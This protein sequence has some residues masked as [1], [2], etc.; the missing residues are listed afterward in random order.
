MRVG[1]DDLGGPPLILSLWQAFLCFRLSLRGNAFGDI[2][3]LC[4]KSM[5]KRTRGTCDISGNPASLTGETPD[6][7]SSHFPLDPLGER[8]KH[9]K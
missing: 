6:T 8:A 1:A 9:T 4:D 7:L 5:Q 3:L 2:L